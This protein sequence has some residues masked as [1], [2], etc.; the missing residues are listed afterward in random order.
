MPKNLHIVFFQKNLAYTAK[1]KRPCSYRSFLLLK[2]PRN[3]RGFL[4]ADPTEFFSFQES[5]DLS[6]H[7]FMLAK[8]RM[9]TTLC[10]DFG[11]FTPVISCKAKKSWPNHSISW[12]QFSTKIVV[13]T[14]LVSSNYPLPSLNHLYSLLSPSFLHI[15][16]SSFF[17]FLI[18]VLLVLKPEVVQLITVYSLSSHNWYLQIYI[19]ENKSLLPQA[20]YI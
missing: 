4:S 2:A 20:L 11:L 12:S 1:V 5:R 16:L 14:T 9:N 8:P 10:P 6:G 15:W 7:P 3:F 17:S 18:L 19:Y 13:A